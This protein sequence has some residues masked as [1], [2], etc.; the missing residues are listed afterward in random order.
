MRMAILLID[1]SGRRSSSAIWMCIWLLV[2]GSVLPVASTMFTQVVIFIAGAIFALDSSIGTW[3]TGLTDKGLSDFFELVAG[4][5]Y[6]IRVGA[7]T[8]VVGLPC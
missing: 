5:K 1:P 7:G 2:D 8:R 4:M 6:E 3:T